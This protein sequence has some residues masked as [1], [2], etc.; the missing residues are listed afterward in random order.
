MHV[1]QTKSQFRTFKPIMVWPMLPRTF[2]EGD[3]VEVFG[4]V[5]NRTDKGQ[6]IKVRLKVENGEI[7][8]REEKFVWVDAKSSVN[9]YWNF[10]AKQP[11]F[12]QLLM[13]VDCPEGSDA[14]LKRLPVIR[15]AAEQIIT[16]SGHVRDGTTF[17]IPNDVDLSS[18]R[19][20]INFAP[21]LAA[22]MADTL[23][24]LV[25]YPYGCVEQTMS[26][27]LPAIKVAQILKQYEVNHPELLKKMP[28][29]VAAGIK[30]CS[31]FN[32]DGGWGWH[33][34]GRR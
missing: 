16:K 11:G 5:H 9:V 23:N 10:V 1:G 24:F 28:G 14:S 21:S 13:S 7:L 25:D 30:D 29:V 27:F 15:A 17:T 18:A 26:R 32:S 20:E 19:L 8:S 22:D 33:G 12:T 6:N 2:V 3:R 4:A 34:S 31:N